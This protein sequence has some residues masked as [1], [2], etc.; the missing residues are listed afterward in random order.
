MAVHYPWIYDLNSCDC[1]MPV[2]ACHSLRHW[3]AVFEVHYHGIWISTYMVSKDRCG[4]KGLHA[5]PGQFYFGSLI[6]QVG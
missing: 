6:L 3:L 1:N 5:D 4:A 2:S